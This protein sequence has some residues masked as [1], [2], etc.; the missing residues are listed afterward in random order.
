M[1]LESLLKIQIVD[2]GSPPRPGSPS[3]APPPSGQPVTGGQP[4]PTPPTGSPATT[5]AAALSVPPKVANLT[6]PAAE[7][8]G[9]LADLAL[10]A[11][12]SKQPLGEFT[13]AVATALT[14]FDAATQKQA[15]TVLGGDPGA[16]AVEL[17]KLLA[18]NPPWVPASAPPPAGTPATTQVQASAP[19]TAAPAP[20]AVAPSAA[21]VPREVDYKPGAAPLPATTDRPASSAVAFDRPQAVVVMGPKPLPVEVTNH[22]EQGGDS[23]GGGQQSARGRGRGAAPAGGRAGAVAGAV[24]AVGS[25]ALGTAKA[26]LDATPALAANRNLEAMTTAAKGAGNA[27]AALGP[28]GAAAGAA[29]KTAAEFAG[30]F[31]KAV[32]AFTDRGRELSAYDARLAKAAA[33][34]DMR[35]LQADLREAQQNGEAMARLI[36]Q[37]SELENTVR[38]LLLPIKQFVVEFLI[39]FVQFVKS[40]LRTML[41]LMQHLPMIGKHAKKALERLDAQQ[42]RQPVDIIGSWLDAAD[43]LGPIGGQQAPNAPID[44]FARMNWAPLLGDL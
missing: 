32:N 40:C 23:G 41:E 2:A 12:E 27:L 1:A 19:V 37:Q 24:G 35:S 34:A 44:P 29:L 39:D 20:I 33:E 6:G 4:A 8:A 10:K 15:V 42:D 11:R 36:E 13:R 31:G 43:G 18:T 16:S 21:A 25:A 30:A 9:E 28:V 38:D 5:A 26:A 7:L 17:A 22:P 14:A 3:A